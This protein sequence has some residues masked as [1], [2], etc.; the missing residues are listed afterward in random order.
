M[1]EEKKRAVKAAEEK[2]K[3]DVK[4]EK[5]REE[6]RKKEEKKKEKEE[7]K[8]DEKRKEQE[9]AEFGEGAGGDDKGEEIGVRYNDLIKLINQ[10]KGG[11]NGFLEIDSNVPWENEEHLEAVSPDK[12][13]PK[14]LL[15]SLTGWGQRGGFGV[16]TSSNPSGYNTWQIVQN[17]LSGK[18]SIVRNGDLVKLVN[19]FDK[20]RG[21]LDTW[22]QTERGG[23]DV[24]TSPEPNREGGSGTWQIVVS[25]RKPKG[26]IVRYGEPVKLINQ[27]PQNDPTNGYLVV[28]DQH[29]YNPTAGYGVETSAS[30]GSLGMW[31]IVRN[32]LGGKVGMVAEAGEASEV[33]EAGE[34][35]FVT[36]MK[37][38]KTASDAAGVGGGM[39]DLSA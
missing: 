27:G 8:M 37:T 11:T 15:D 36:P 14:T 16:E 20:G 1:I 6:E 29:E 17:D 3:Q 30:P 7:K 21:Y 23:Y 32:D 22:G 34:A 4:D 24:E 9:M 2:R 13:K 5:R 10:H 25:G 31:K 18:D 12:A 38:G 26:S 39:A 33:S 35:G 19:Q 28:W